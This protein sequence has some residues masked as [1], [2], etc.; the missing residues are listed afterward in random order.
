MDVVPALFALWRK[1][2]ILSLVGGCPGKWVRPN[3]LAWDEH[4][5][6]TEL[7]APR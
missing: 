2:A 4:L 7:Y 5:T 1:R 6:F 3:G